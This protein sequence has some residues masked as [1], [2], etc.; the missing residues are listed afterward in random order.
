MKRQMTKRI[1]VRQGEKTAITSNGRWKPW[2][3]VW[4][5]PVQRMYAKDS[6][7]ILRN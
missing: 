1:S 7:K 4:Q 5:K 6:E 2:D 3:R